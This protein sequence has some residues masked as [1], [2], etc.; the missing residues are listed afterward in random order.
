MI[1]LIQ[2]ETITTET[3]VDFKDAR[4]VRIYQTN[5]D[6]YVVFEEEV[7]DQSLLNRWTLLL[8]KD[9]LN[10]VSREI[11]A[12]P[13]SSEQ[14]KAIHAKKKKEEE[15]KLP[16]LTVLP[17]EKA[18]PI[19]WKDPEIERSMRK[20][21]SRASDPD[22]AT[23]ILQMVFRWHSKNDYSKWHDKN[24]NL[25]H[26]LKKVIPNQFGLH[27]S[28]ARRIY[29]AQTYPDVTRAYVNNWK[30]LIVKLDSEGRHNAV[31][32]YIRKHYGPYKK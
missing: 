27:F 13:L 23:S 7:E 18:E 3:S 12:R 17:P 29:L 9:Q 8:T 11:N 1:E 2:K 6:I 24:H 16:D 25:G 20:C 32:E 5:N 21:S 15:Q 4:I 10:A 30:K 14:L 31:P 28:V 26:L 22:K 19:N